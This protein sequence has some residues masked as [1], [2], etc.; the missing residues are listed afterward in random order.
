MVH[1]YMLL[2]RYEWWGSFHRH[3]FNGNF[4][5][6]RLASCPYSSAESIPHFLPSCRVFLIPSKQLV[7]IFPILHL[8]QCLKLLDDPVFCSLEHLFIH[9][10]ASFYLFLLFYLAILMAVFANF[11]KNVM[12]ILCSNNL[13]PMFLTNKIPCQQNVIQFTKET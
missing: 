12:L 2:Q 5:R 9:K 4:L 13:Q 1:F 10:V 7:V 3:P 8:N 6:H 11:C